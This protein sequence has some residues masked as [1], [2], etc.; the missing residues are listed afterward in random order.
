MSGIFSC[1]LPRYRVLIAKR[2]LVGRIGDNCIVVRSVSAQ[3]VYYLNFGIEPKIGK[4]GMER[5]T[6]FLVLI[7][8]INVSALRYHGIIVS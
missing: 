8:R 1:L 7:G 6:R 5:G 4:W 3:T 2:S